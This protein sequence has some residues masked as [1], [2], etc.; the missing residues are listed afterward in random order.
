MPVTR[1][2][3]RTLGQFLPNGATP[4]AFHDGETF[5][6]AGTAGKRT[7]WLR[8]RTDI[9]LYVRITSTA[10]NL[11]NSAIWE[12]TVMIM[13]VEMFPSTAG[14]LISDTPITNTTPNPASTG[15]AQWEY[16]YPELMNIDFNAPEV[17][18]VVWRPRQGTVDTQSR[19]RVPIGVGLDV[20]LAWEI[21]DGAGLIN[22]THGGVTYNL[23]ARF[24]QEIW[25]STE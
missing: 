2:S 23:G 10:T 5:T 16:L 20:W 13:G 6:V 4:T 19:R 3:D 15:W 24:A 7:S 14:E 22:G 9:E 21:Q 18:T 8:T 25:W 12:E 11:I 1:F 17:A